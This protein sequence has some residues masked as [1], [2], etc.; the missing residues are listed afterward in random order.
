MKIIGRIFAGCIALAMV[1]ACTSKEEEEVIVQEIDISQPQAEKVNPVAEEK[2]AEG[3]FSERFPKKDS[4]EGYGES[5]DGH[6]AAL[7]ARKVER[8]IFIPET[9]KGKWKAVKILIGDKTDEEKN[10]IRIV[11]LGSSF[12]IADS[13]IKVTVGPFFPNFVMDRTHY[14]SMDNQV[15]NPAV[16]MS[17]EENG[18][19]IYKGWAFEKHPTLYAFE[20]EKYSLQL[21]GS[22]AADVS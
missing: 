21:M 20:H 22:I 8:E 12:E 19:N 9:V 11:E 3:S 5:V 10:E 7:E 18:K 4:S 14:T 16:Q 15:I 17:V 6:P 13:G 2:Y 1:S